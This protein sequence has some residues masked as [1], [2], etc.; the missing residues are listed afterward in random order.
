MSEPFI[1]EIMM[2]GGNFAPRGWALCNGQLLPIAQNTAL[3]S[4][5]GTTYG[6]DGITTFALPNMQGRVPMHWG[7]GPGLTPHAIGESS[8]TESVTLVSSQMPAHTHLATA[9]STDGNSTSPA[10]AVWA[11]AVDANSQQVSSYGTTAN[12]TMSP[13]AFSLAGGSQPHDNMQPYLCVTFIIALEGIF[14]SRS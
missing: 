1:G 3:F 9:S 7:T 8:G 6:G 10:N 2:F 13:Q 5:L 4:I 11:T 14:P 12:T